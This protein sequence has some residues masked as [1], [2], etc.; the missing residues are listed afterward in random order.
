MKSRSAFFKVLFA[1]FT[2]IA[3]SMAGLGA[4]NAADPTG[5]TREF[6][7]MTS[8]GTSA[9]VSDLSNCN[10]CT[11]SVNGG[12]LSVSGSGPTFTVSSNTGGNYIVV[13]TASKFGND[14]TNGSDTPNT[15]IS[16]WIV[17]LAGAGSSGAA[18]SST[19][20]GFKIT[21]KGYVQGNAKYKGKLDDLRAKNVAKYLQKVGLAGEYTV[22]G[23]NA[24]TDKKTGR[25]AVIEV[26][27]LSDGSVHTLTVTFNGTSS[28]LSSKSKKAIS[29]FVKSLN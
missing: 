4:A 27:K 13:V 11:Y 23:L 12:G 10:K 21:V 22:L 7:Q 29:A 14:T 26:T 17:T 19:A 20:S 6:M 8:G 2:S 25:T 28:T 3:I 24:V 1:G 15:Y 5:N 16:T 18:A 9:T